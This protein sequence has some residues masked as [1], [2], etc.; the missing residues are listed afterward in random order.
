MEEI[1]T[2]E[3]MTSEA[4]LL[5]VRPAS[6]ASR[7]AA[8]FIDVVATVFLFLFLTWPTSW[9]VD[10]TSYGNTGATP[11]ILLLVVCLVIAPTAVE[12]L[13]QG[14]S[15]GKLALGLRIVRDDGGPI[16]LRHAFIRALTGVLEIWISL[17]SIAIL[18]SLFN[19]RGKRLGDFLAGTY[20]MRVRAAKSNSAIWMPPE[21]A[22][23]AAAADIR[24][25]PDTLAL[26][27]RQILTRLPT[28]NPVSAGQ[29]VGQMAAEL[30]AYVAPSAPYGTPPDRFI[31]A[32]IVERRSR[33][34]AIMLRQQ[35]RLRRETAAVQQ[36]PFGIRD[37]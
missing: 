18:T 14:R 15:L 25:L 23:W 37:A 17:G 28:L 20:S 16:R 5:E 36:L 2:H 19:D 11:V 27:A 26:R 22:A 21:L 1:E 12:S 6:F 7:G 13:S 4:V 35:D 3:V 24:P 10:N 31:A 32:V 30:E 34:Y 8:S 33:E 9:L 29:L